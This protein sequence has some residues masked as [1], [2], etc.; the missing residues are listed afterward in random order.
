MTTVL[1]VKQLKHL[2]RKVLCPPGDD[3]DAGSD[4]EEF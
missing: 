2:E 1:Q 3:N 4:E